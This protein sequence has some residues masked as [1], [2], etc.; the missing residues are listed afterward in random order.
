MDLA[1]AI[2]IHK[3]QS[4]TL[5]NYGIHLPS[6]RKLPDAALY[7]ALSRSTLPSDVTIYNFSEDLHS[8][9]KHLNVSYKALKFALEKNLL[10]VEEIQKIK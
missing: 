6:D 2:T 9:R 1:Y 8:F 3:S 4:Q 5:T 7:V 10:D